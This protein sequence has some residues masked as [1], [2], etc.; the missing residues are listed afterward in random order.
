M[1]LCTYQ[2]PQDEGVLIGPRGGQA[3]ISRGD[4]ASL[5][6]SGEGKRESF[7][8]ALEQLFYRK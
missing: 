8:G 4:A 5:V 1:S 3:P 7:H 6:G 2:K